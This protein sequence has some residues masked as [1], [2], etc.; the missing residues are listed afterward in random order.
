[1]Y[2]QFNEA[3]KGWATLHNKLMQAK[4]KG[5]GIK[6]RKNSPSKRE[7][8]TAIREKFSHKDGAINR[9]TFTNVSRSLI[10]T[11]R[12]AGKGLGGVKGSN[13]VTAKGD[14]KRTD[15]KSLGKAPG[16][17][18]E[19]PFISAVLDDE[20]GMDKLGDIVTEQ[21]ADAIVNAVMIK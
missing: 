12:G 9:I 20:G 19:K 17:R 11:T 2:E 10:Y 13:W 14:R 8:L 16:T 7:S 3:V 5:M 6:H 4:G 15:P 1:M 18:T 21:Q